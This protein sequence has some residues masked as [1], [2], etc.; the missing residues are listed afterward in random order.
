MSL[1]KSGLACVSCL[2][3]LSCIKLCIFLCRLVLFVSTLAE[4]LAGKTILFCLQIEELF[5]VM[6]YRMNCV[7]NT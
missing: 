7:P 3:L 2:G 6:V 5:I 1:T 4:R